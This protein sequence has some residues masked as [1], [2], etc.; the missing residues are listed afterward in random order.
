LISRREAAANAGISK[1]RK[2]P[3]CGNFQQVTAVRVTNVPAEQFEKAVE[4]DKPQIVTA[5]AEMGKESWPALYVKIGFGYRTTFGQEDASTASQAPGN[6]R[7]RG[8]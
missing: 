2:F 5:L 4:S 3:Y 1:D 8:S 7:S 6:R